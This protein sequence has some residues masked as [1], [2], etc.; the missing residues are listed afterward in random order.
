MRAVHVLTALAALTTAVAAGCGGDAMPV[1]VTSSLA[2]PAPVV[3][4]ARG[5]ASAR[6]LR[7]VSYNVNFGLDGDA[8]GVE[9]IARVDP[10]VVFLQE[11]TPAWQH[12]LV[13]GLGARLPHH[14]FDPSDSWPAGGLGVMSRFAIV[15]AETLP[16]AGGPFFASRV[17]LA[18]LDGPVQVLHVHLRPPMSDG[19][20]WVIGYF[21]TR[22]D[23]VREITGHHQ[24]L[25]PGLPTL[26]VG[27]FNEEGDG[28]AVRFLT[29][30]GLADV[31]PRFVG[32]RPTWQWA[33]PSGLTLRL[34]L[35]HLLHDAHFVAID[36]GIVAAGR[37]DHVPIW[38]DLERP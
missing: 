21:S 19:G 2:V 24:A 13:A 34:Q 9:A 18:T 20:S 27:D 31:L 30:R 22:D 37:S 3:A 8:A 6:A 7:V 38:V 26:V 15:S 12:A 23:R 29:E 4:P 32:A 10:D 33:L 11:T 35:D 17:V 25:A 14:R 1:A 28:G 36:A 5:P 16:S